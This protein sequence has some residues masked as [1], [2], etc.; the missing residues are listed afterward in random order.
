MPIDPFTIFSIV[1]SVAGGFGQMKAAELEAYNLE[2]QAISQRAQDE[3][4]KAE[5]KQRAT[6]RVEE[7]Q[8]ATSTNIAQ[9]SMT[10]DIGSD[11]SVQAFLEKQKETVGKDISRLGRQS[12]MQSMQAKGQ[13]AAER[14]AG[15]DA[16]IGSLF[17]AAGTYQKGLM[18]QNDLGANWWKG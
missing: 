10:R 9:F 16:F 15:R 6:A 17:S 14:R 1:S 5:A 8:A 4:Q 3:M 18:I 11:R 13:A 2:T 7:W 12:Q